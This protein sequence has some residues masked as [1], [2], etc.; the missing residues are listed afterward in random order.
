MLV[1]QYST[2]TAIQERLFYVTEHIFYFP[3]ICEG[4]QQVSDKCYA[5]KLEECYDEQDV[6]FHMAYLLADLQTNGVMLSQHMITGVKVIGIKPRSDNATN[7]SSTVATSP[8]EDYT[9]D[10][11]D[12]P[13][14]DGSFQMEYPRR[15]EC[16]NLKYLHTFPPIIFS[17][18]INSVFL[19]NIDLVGW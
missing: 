9:I 4:L 6:K 18:K 16:I 19:N 3:T 2:F 10:I 8:T 17:E 11:S 15:Y 1:V 12:C 5:V 13:V 14:F 7:T